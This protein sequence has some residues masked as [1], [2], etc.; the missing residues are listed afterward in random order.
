MHCQSLDTLEDMQEERKKKV[1]QFVSM[2]RKNISS[3]GKL[4]ETNTTPV[5]ESSLS[6]GKQEEKVV[7]Q[8]GP[9]LEKEEEKY[10]KS[11]DRDD[12]SASKKKKSKHSRHKYEDDREKYF[13][14]IYLS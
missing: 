13:T 8:I 7:F 6:N 11:K 1:E 5:D 10:E 14:L 9:Q 4:L 3:N 12:K 2:L